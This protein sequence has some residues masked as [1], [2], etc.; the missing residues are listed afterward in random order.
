MVDDTR[1]RAAI[2]GADRHLNAW[3]G[4]PPVRRQLEALA[5]ATGAD[6]RADHYG[7]GERTERVERRVAELL[8]KEAAVFLPSGTMAQP[9][10]LRIW[11]DRRGNRTVAF[12]PTCHLELHEERAYAH[13]HGLQARLVGD[14]HGLIRL[15]DLEA[16][17]EP[18]AVLLLE[19]P[20]RET[21]GQLPEW[22]DLVA[23]VEWARE[24][25]I[26]VHLDGAR[27]WE[28][29]TYYERPH[30]EVAGLFDSVYVSFYKGL[31]AMA[32]AALAGD[33]DLVAEARIWQRRQGGNLVPMHPFVVSVETALER[34]ERAPAFLAHALALAASLATLDGLEV[35]PDPPQTAL[36]HLLLRGERE[37]LSEA[38]LDVAEERKVFVFGDPSST[39]SPSWQTIEVRV[40]EVSLAIE[41]DELRDLFAEILERAAA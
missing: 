25:G 10:A 13:L 19:L 41:P 15:E 17:K 30:A 14:P 12:H 32:G 11:S 26:A 3:H 20:Q 34:L 27:L 38:A 7:R 31:G 5:E 23:Q 28:A 36:F 4:T 37:R 39:M 2:A 9:I 40:G 18:V 33:A 8:G 24:R 22:D 35:V 29:V 21:G 1:I 6:E 16:I